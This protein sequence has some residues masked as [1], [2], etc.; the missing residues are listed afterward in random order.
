ME[1]SLNVADVNVVL[2]TL[3][4]TFQTSLTWCFQIAGRNDSLW[5]SVVFWFMYKYIIENTYRKSSYETKSDQFLR[6]LKK[7]KFLPT[8]YRKGKALLSYSK[9]PAQLVQKPTWTT[10]YQ[11]CFQTICCKSKSKTAAFA[12]N[13]NRREKHELLF[14]ICSK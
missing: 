12:V 2:S 13:L 9:V 7:G 8:V 1:R 5:I 4:E 10:L 6:V 3:R 14:Q 11:G